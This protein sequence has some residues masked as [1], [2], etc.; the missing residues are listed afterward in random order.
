M[1]VSPVPRSQ[2]VRSLPTQLRNLTHP[3]KLLTS[4]GLLACAVYQCDVMSVLFLVTGESTVV[5]EC[6]FI[7]RQS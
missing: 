7:A 5:S 6:L 3:L 1:K 2:T 4:H